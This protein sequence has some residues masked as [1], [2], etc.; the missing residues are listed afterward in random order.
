MHVNFL[1]AL[2][3]DP[4]VRIGGDTGHPIATL[5]PEDASAKDFYELAALVVMHA[6]EA[7]Q[8]TGPTMTVSD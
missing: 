1:G 3:L 4:R 2:P 6:R 5:G 8:E 7:S